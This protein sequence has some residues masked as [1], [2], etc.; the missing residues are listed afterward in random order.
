[1]TNDD[2]LHVTYNAMQLV[3]AGMALY[4]LEV[5]TWQRS[6]YNSDVHAERYAR[7]AIAPRHTPRRRRGAH[8]DSGT[9]A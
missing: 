9:L 6:G 4:A 8:H 3:V 5:Q 1:M 7:N 2:A